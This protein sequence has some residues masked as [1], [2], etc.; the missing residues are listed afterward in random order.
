MESFLALRIRPWIRRLVTRL[1]AIVPALLTIW[2]AGDAGLNNLLVFSQVILS[3]QL[4]FALVP[5]VIFTGSPRLM[6]KFVNSTVEA[7]ASW[8]AVI[9]MTLLNAWLVVSSILQVTS[10]M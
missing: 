8:T 5:L 9:L 10:V 6:G 4:P 3:V 7:T 1:L 2:I